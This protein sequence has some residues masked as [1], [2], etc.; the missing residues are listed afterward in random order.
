MRG[1]SSLIARSR[2]RNSTEQELEHHDVAGLGEVDGFA[3]QLFYLAV[4]QRGRDDRRAIF[5]S[6]F[7]PGIAVGE[8]TA[9]SGGY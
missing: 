2:G 1:K 5:G 3:H 7:S 8:W 6:A 4:D 9:A